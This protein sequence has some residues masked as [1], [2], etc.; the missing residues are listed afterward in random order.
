[1]N[2]FEVVLSYAQVRKDFGLNANETRPCAN[3]CACV[4]VCRPK[5]AGLYSQDT[6]MP[7]GRI[8]VQTIAKCKDSGETGAAKDG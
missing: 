1:M 4:R 5:E 6:S 2:E 3:V 8:G 7:L